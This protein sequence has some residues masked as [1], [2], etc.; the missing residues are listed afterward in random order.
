MD[1]GKD[2]VSMFGGSMTPADV[3]QSIDQRRAELAATAKDPAW[4]N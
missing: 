4:A 3:M 2:L 1:I